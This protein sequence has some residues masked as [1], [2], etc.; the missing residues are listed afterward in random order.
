MNV[1]KYFRG[2]YT[3]EELLAEQSF[4]SR[5]QRSSNWDEMWNRF[6]AYLGEQCIGSC[7]SETTMT[8]VPCCTFCPIQCSNKN[9]QFSR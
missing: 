3:R 6:V 8:P 1:F 2:G 4:T 7:K 9:A 5:G